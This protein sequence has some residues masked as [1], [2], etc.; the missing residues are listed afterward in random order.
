MEKLFLCLS[1]IILSLSH[2]G[3]AF[4]QPADIYN[5]GSINEEMKKDA[6]TVKRYEKVEMDISGPDKVSMHSREVIT[7][8]NE[9]GN[10]DLNF[11]M[12]TSK[13]LSLE[14]VDIKLYDKSGTLLEK[15]KKKDLSSHS[16]G[17]G[18]VEDGFIYF[19]RLSAG[20]YP[21]TIEKEYTIRFRGMIQIPSFYF[22]QP[23]QSVEYSTLLIKYPSSINVNYK[24]FHLNKNPGRMTNGN[25]EVVQFEAESLPAVKYEDHSGP[26]IKDFPH[27]LFNSDKIVYD[28]YA[29]NLSTW[30]DMGLWY[31]SLVKNTNKLA[32]AKQDEIRSLV[33]NAG[34]DREKVRIVYQYL[35]NNFRYVSIQLGIGGFKPF[36]AD[37]VHDKKYGDCKG[38]SNY[39]EA[40]LAAI[41]I[42]SYSA[43][44]N[45]GDEDTYMDPEFPH[46]RFDHQILMVPLD[47][48]TIW[49]ECTSNYNEFGH[50]GSFTENRYALVLTENGGKLIKTPA[51]KATDNTLTSMADININSDGEAKVIARYYA[52]GEYRYMLVNISRESSDIHKKYAINYFGIPDPDGFEMNFSTKESQPYTC[53]VN[54]DLEKIYEFKAGSKLFIRPRMYN[55]WQL[56][57][58]PAEKREHD[59]YL[60]HPLQK[61]DTTAF[62]L[63][64]GY[65]LESLP[66]DK[67]ISFAKGRYESHYWAD[68]KSRTIYSTASLTIDS[69]KIEPA[70]YEEA[71]MFFDQVIEDGNQKIICKNNN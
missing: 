45:S 15:Y 6:Q 51:S 43:W 14:E 66:R 28:G 60:A 8:L 67:N 31:N 34:S 40:C 55:I 63:P 44:I 70:L 13:S 2:Q 41:N 20:S 50:L 18:L 54:L 12:Y 35:Q 11:S 38:L 29:G 25:S 26:W 16:A 7:I 61:S 69:Y 9:K 4:Q 1:L 48:D 57:L 52:T 32:V 49:L 5:A 62:H 46:D 39:M 53:N 23:F 10:A 65:S 3:L 71:R 42:K 19:I 21:V 27:V 37:F 47:K 22:S 17:S 64:E 33:A 56:T 68:E 30:K 58:N 24:A 36:A 59:Y